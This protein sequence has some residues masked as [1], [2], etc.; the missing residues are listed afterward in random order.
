MNAARIARLP[1]R[2]IVAVRGPD[3]E[4]LLQGLVTNDIALLAR[5]PAGGLL[6]AIHA[7]LLSPQGKILFDFFVVRDGAAGFLLEVCRAQ[8]SNLIRRLT[9]YRLRSK[10]EFEDV[11]SVAE[12]WAVWGADLPPLGDDHLEPVGETDD[13]FCYD[14]S[15]R[16]F[17]DPRLEQLGRRWLLPARHADGI[18]AGIP[19]LE[20]GTEAAYHAHRIGLG[21]PEGGKDYAFGDAF[22][23]E[24]N[25]DRLHGVSF[26]KGCFVGQE[27]VSRMQHR[28]SVRKR[29]V[30]I[31]GAGPLAAGAEVKAGDA[32]IGTVGS[33]AGARALALMR[34]DRAAEAADKG[35][36]LA[37]GGVAISLVKPDWAA[38]ASAGAS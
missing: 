38:P 23:H 13:I 1:D 12:V 35:I 29:V 15:P 3:A 14:L 16:A 11:S 2:A 21:V 19:R 31:E 17:A 37:A 25:F 36:P 33:V 32:V 26:D 6:P 5:E 8:A 7:A 24:A 9:L 18:L 4:K 34:L 20:P 10:V 27:V 22:P 28:A 30:P